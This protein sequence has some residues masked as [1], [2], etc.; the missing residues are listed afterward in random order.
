MKNLIRAL[1]N[2]YRVD[3]YADGSRLASHYARNMPDAIEWAAG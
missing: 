1:R 2:P 3:V